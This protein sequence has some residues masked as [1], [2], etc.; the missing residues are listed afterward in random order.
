MQNMREQI[1]GL[2]NTVESFRVALVRERLVESSQ[3]LQAEFAKLQSDVDR[4][5]KTQEELAASG[6]GVDL[7]SAGPGFVVAFCRIKGRDYCHVSRL[8]PVENMDDW[9]QV[10]YS[11]SGL[12][13]AGWWIDAHPAFYEHIK[14]EESQRKRAPILHEHIKRTEQQRKRD[15]FKAEEELKQRSRRTI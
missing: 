15:S 14:Y 6:V 9:R 1:S 4:A 3:V 7:H 13:G 5:R 12:G 11:L 2:A 8:R 10:K